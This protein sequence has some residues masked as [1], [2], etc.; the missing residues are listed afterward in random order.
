MKKFL[1]LILILFIMG[2]KMSETK[3]KLPNPVIKG[4]SSV[5][6]A[7]FK[8]RSIRKFKKGNLNL[9]LISQLLW[10]AY[11]ITDDRGFKTVPSAGATYPLKIYLVAG[12]VSDL[13]S[14]IYKY[15]PEEHSLIKIIEKDVRNE[16]MK[17]ALRQNFISE[18]QIIIII[19]ADFKRTT[20]YYGERG[21]MYVYIEAGHSG[22][23]IYLQAESLNLGTVAVGAFNDDEVSKLLKLPEN[24]KPIYI[25]PVGIK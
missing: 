5:E 4:K 7:L 12:D 8:R 23:N 24:E 16:L 9:N 18:A 21:I 22:Q 6:E 1:Y 20:G 15:I 11:G 3:I 17:A 13:K 2:Y 25:F 10:A 19:T 14:G